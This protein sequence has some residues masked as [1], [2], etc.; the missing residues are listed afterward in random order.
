M[1][2]ICVFKKKPD[3]GVH[4]Q[5][6]THRPVPRPPRCSCLLFA[7]ARTCIA[8]PTTTAIERNGHIICIAVWQLQVGPCC[9]LHWPLS[10]SSNPPS[11][12]RSWLVADCGTCHAAPARGRALWTHNSKCTTKN[13]SQ[14]WCLFVCISQCGHGAFSVERE[15]QHLCLLRLLV[16]LGDRLL[17]RLH[18]VR[19]ITVI[20]Y[21]PPVLLSM[22][23][24]GGRAKPGIGGVV[25]VG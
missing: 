4:H 21:D 8:Q 15:E 1:L 13:N 11:A 9:L 17:H 18:R 12:A 5:P 16:E 2:R 19:F 22:G 7:R 3:P 20:D 14:G 23:L 24:S 10:R 6:H 25:F